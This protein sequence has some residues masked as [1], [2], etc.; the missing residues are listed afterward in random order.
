[1]TTA[2][3][4]PRRVAAKTVSA[5]ADVSERR[6]VPER[7]GASERPG[8]SARRTAGPILR[9]LAAALAIGAAAAVFAAPAQADSRVY[10]GVGVGSSYG[11][12]HGYGHGYYGYSYRR[13]P[14]VYLPP[15]AVIYE[16]EPD[17]VYVQPPA[18]RVERVDRSY[19]REYTS[20]ATIAGKKQ[21]TFGTACR[22][23]DGSW[24]IIN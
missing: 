2:N 22:Q 21:P 23:P 24:R 5:P 10:V 17:V 12:G 4:S 8:V 6:N 7:P 16:Q 20:S 11:Y 1:M 9:R 18:A 3:S 14:N 15:P 13:P 19:C